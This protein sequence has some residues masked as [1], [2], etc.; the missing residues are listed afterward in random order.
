MPMEANMWKRLLWAIGALALMSGYPSCLF[1]GERAADGQTA[2]RR[3]GAD[4]FFSGGSLNVSH[5]VDGDLIA[6]GGNLDVEAPVGG[7][8]LVVGGNLRFG[9]EVGQ[10]IY[11]L[12]GQVKVDAKVGRNVRV[13]GG[14]VDIGPNAQVAGNLTT[15]GGQVNVN[16][17]VIGYV[18]VA[19]G[20][21]VID[22]P[23]GGDVVAASGQVEL[24]PNARIAGKLRYRSPDDLK[25]DPAAQVAG[26]VER[27]ALSPGQ[28]S[29]WR[30]HRRFLVGGASMLWTL[31]MM[32]L[33]TVLLVAFPGFY[34]RVTRTL[35]A[36]PGMSVLSGLVLLA[37]APL[38]ALILLISIIGVPLAL[39]S[40]ALYLAALPVGYASGGIALGN[41]ALGR[42]RPDQATLPGWRIGAALLAL[43]SMALLR[44][45]PGVGALVGFGALLA[46]LGALLLQLQRAPSAS[47][48]A[49]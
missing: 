30:G 46:G 33:A 36:R 32:V 21:V 40:L 45:I 35:R 26:G 29:R 2:E 9:S 38:A 22:A 48:T 24:G 17:R 3:M 8:A 23:V 43:F 31:G 49:Q 25:R 12:G 11:A 7:D 4:R 15:A 27:L 14:Q 47:G 6:A 44:W 5:P 28:E 42:F 13:A 34:D 41:W 10:S 19:G 37:C 1:A 39:I 20:R 18:Q 16:G